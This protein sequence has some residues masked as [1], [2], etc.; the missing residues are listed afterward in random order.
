[1]KNRKTGLQSVQALCR[2]AILTALYVVLTT[3]LSLK[4]P[5][6][7]RITFAS[8]PILLSAIQFATG[9]IVALPLMLLTETPT[10][11]NIVACWTSIIYA[12]VFSGAMGYTLQM[13]G[14]KYTDPT[15]ASL[16]MCLESVFAAIGG[17]ILLGEVLSV[18]ELLGCLLMLSASVIAQLPEKRSSIA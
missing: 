9:A 2:M 16:L 14:Q 4:L 6:D 10:M 7:I 8:L 17:W 5:G 1:M 11:P 13:V 18:R 12:A 3:T 15:L